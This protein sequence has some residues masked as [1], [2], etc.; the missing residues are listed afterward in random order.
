MEIEVQGWR[1][2]PAEWHA[3][4]GIPPNEL[5][6]LSSEQ[7]EVARKLGISEED[8]ARSALAGQRTQEILLQKTERL[9]RF[10]E[11]RIEASRLPAKINRIVLVAV[12][13]KF[14]VEL[15]VNR[16]P[17]FLR[18]DEAVVDDFFDSGSQG[19][20]ESLGRILDRALLGVT[21]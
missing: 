15:E 6:A 16:R 10:L 7:R 4:R 11:K 19:A 20:E 13:Q 8:Y 9:A 21:A 12:E 18:I 14:T 2:Y 5:P 1:A 17:L 3:V